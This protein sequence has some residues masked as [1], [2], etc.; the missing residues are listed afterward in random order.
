MKAVKK[1]AKKRVPKKVA[2]TEIVPRVVETIPQAITERETALPMNVGVDMQSLME[3]SIDKMV[4]LD[5][6][7]K[8]IALIQAQRDRF[9]K[10]QFN[11]DFA[12]AQGEYP[13]IEKKGE[14]RDTEKACPVCHGKPG[15]QDTCSACDGTGHR[16]LYRYAQLEDIIEKIAPI[17][18]RHGL[19]ATASSEPFKDEALGTMMRGVCIMKH[20]DGHEVLTTVKVPIGDGTRL[21]S[22]MQKYRAAATFA[23]RHAY[24]EAHNLAMRGEDVESGDDEPPRVAEPQPKAG[25]KVQE[26]GKVE[27]SIYPDAELKAARAELQAVFSKM[28]KAVANTKGE[29]VMLYK[30]EELN[31]MKEQAKAATTDIAKLREY[32]IDWTAGYTEKLADLSLEGSK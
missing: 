4:P 24:I 20:R 23:R 16:L 12:L 26:N 2:T 30:V 15:V 17:D 11:R 3:R 21:M 5:Y 25:V 6:M 14:A 18:S 29:M 27:Q 7:E 9:A 28:A 31:A 32:T 13:V 8:L 22:G 19:S 10:E 1:V